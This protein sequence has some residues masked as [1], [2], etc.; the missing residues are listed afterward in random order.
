MSVGA[1]APTSFT[2]VDG[3]TNAASVDLAG[4]SNRGSNLT[5]VAPTNS[6]AVDKLGNTVTFGGTS[7]ANPNMAGIAS[8]V[9]SVN[10]SL[11]GAD[12]RTILKSTAMDLGVAGRDD[13]FGSG[14]V[15]ADAAVRRAFAL[16]RDPALA[17]INTF[18]PALPIRQY[19]IDP[20]LVRR[21]TIPDPVARLPLPKFG[22]LAVSRL[23]GTT[24]RVA[25]SVPPGAGVGG[26]SLRAV[27]DDLVTTARRGDYADMDGVLELRSGAWRH[28]ASPFA[29]GRLLDVHDAA[30]NRGS[31]GCSLV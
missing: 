7:A 23:G 3:L 4:Y 15:N 1:L 24:L 29:S 13:R 16:N 22:Q 12:V 2:T 14:L 31:A 5:M 26:L 28:G 20:K 19:V 9:W 25:P 18:Q 10:P 21:I 27:N 6:P 17:K 30:A 8:L 11:S